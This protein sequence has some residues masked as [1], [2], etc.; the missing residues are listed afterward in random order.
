MYVLLW[1]NYVCMGC[2]ATVAGLMR[3]RPWFFFILKLRCPRTANSYAFPPQ[4]Q[5]LKDISFHIKSNITQHLIIAYPSITL[6]LYN[7]RTYVYIHPMVL[8]CQATKVVV[9]HQSVPTSVQGKYNYCCAYINLQQH[10]QQKL[11]SAVQPRR[12]SAW[13]LQLQSSWMSLQHRLTTHL[14]HPSIWRTYTKG[15][16]VI[17]YW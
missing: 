4:T 15:T 1:L 13:P 7:A 11:E 16:S 12:W 14:H 17:L 2:K 9:N 5:M 6:F 8:H 3:L 10:H